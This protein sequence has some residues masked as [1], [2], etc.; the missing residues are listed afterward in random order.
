MISVKVQDAIVENVVEEFDDREKKEFFK[1]MLDQW[2][3]MCE[4]IESAVDNVADATKVKSA[5]DYHRLDTIARDVYLE[6]FFKMHYK[7]KN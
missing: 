3:D 4:D 7:S 5:E 2:I 1:I 6:T